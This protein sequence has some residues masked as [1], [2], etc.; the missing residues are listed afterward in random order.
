MRWMTEILQSLKKDMIGSPVPHTDTG[1]QAC[2]ICEKMNR[3]CEANSVPEIEDPVFEDGEQVIFR[4]SKAGDEYQAG[5]ESDFWTTGAFHYRHHEEEAEFEL[6]GETGKHDVLA[7]AT[8]EATGVDYGKELA[9]LSGEYSPD[10]ETDALTFT[11]IEVVKYSNPTEGEQ[12]V[13]EEGEPPEPVVD[14]PGL[15]QNLLPEVVQ[16]RLAT[17]VRKHQ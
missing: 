9:E 17:Y 8:V 1:R 15:R 10:Q 13:V 3:V 4:A 2:S 11:Q 7:K 6:G 16:K 12:N 5:E 14:L